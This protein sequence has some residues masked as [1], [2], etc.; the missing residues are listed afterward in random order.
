MLDTVVNQVERNSR[1]GLA[2]DID[3]ADVASI[4]AATDKYFNRFIIII[5]FGLIF[6][7]LTKK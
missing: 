3:T 5:D 1:L 2:E 7:K 6:R 4:N